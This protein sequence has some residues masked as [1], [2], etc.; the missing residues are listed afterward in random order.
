MA[1]TGCHPILSFSSFC[2]DEFIAINRYNSG[3]IKFLSGGRLS[4]QV[5]A[6]KWRPR[7]FSEVVG[8]KHVLKALIHALDNDRLHHA[9]L[10]SGTRGVGKTT[11]G[12]IFAKSL[13][14]ENGVTSSPCGVC[15]SCKEIDEGRFV[16]LLEVD[17]ASRT[18]VDETRELLE[19][20]QYAPTR[21]RYKVYL[22][23]EVHM[24]TTHS[25]NALL[26]TLEE[27]PPH[28]KFILA[29][30]DP[31]KLPITILS[32]CL[33]FNLKAIDA[34]SIFDHMQYVLE[35]ENIPAEPVALKL[36]ARSALGSLRDALSLLDQAIA[37]GNGEVG[38]DAVREML[39]AIERTEIYEIITAL[40][41]NDPQ[42]M[43]QQVNKL[44][45]SGCVYANVL[46]ELISVLHTMAVAQVVPGALEEDQEQIVN[47]AKECSADDIQLYYQIALMGQK[48]LPLAPDPKAGF[49]M[50]LLR[51]YAFRPDDAEV[52]TTPSAPPV[53]NVKP[54]P[55]TAAS[56]ASPAQAAR[57]QIRSEANPAAL[58][59]NNPPKQEK[60]GISTE[61]SS[62]DL[63]WDRVVAQLPVS[64]IARQVVANS[65]LVSKQD[66]L[67]KLKLDPINARM[68]GDSVVQRLQQALSQFYSEKLRIQLIET[69]VA[70]ET[71]AVIA[72]KHEQNELQQAVN[73]MAT[74]PNIKAIEETF[75]TKLDTNSVRLI[76][77]N[78]EV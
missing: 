68:A 2:L 1:G 4:Y 29:T 14:C 45:E 7:Q 66:G 60:A 43:F 3:L 46:S 40:I 12:R 24:L 19:N 50:V 76:K 36:I 18:K 67:V 33:K 64:G 17:A 25:F 44:A 42:A 74:D 20:V 78:D 47:L 70:E 15:T 69:N 21:G 57:Q 13:N 49:E 38:D 23:D 53:A 63:P 55:N 37:H 41:Q 52:Q 11:L 30:T 28:V 6:R 59:K 9:Y 22:I 16:D 62:K 65:V 75:N 39:G 72:A 10:F 26:K 27:P 34:E 48:D 8:Q 54:N 32:R 35:Q 31:Q 56:N 71:P 5:L 61:S 58:K 77:N 73:D 51:M